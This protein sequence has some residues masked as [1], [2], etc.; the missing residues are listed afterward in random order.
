M[1]RAEL[2]LMSSVSVLNTGQCLHVIIAAT[3]VPIGRDLCGPPE[4]ITEEII[5]GDGGVVKGSHIYS[6]S[7]G[8]MHVV[9]T[10]EIKGDKEE[11]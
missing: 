4:R 10:Q 1:T 9:G 7:C 8:K 11:Q 5:G 6:D 3:R 2:P